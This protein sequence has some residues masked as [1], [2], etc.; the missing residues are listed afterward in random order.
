MQVYEY[1]SERIADGRLPSG[2]V[3]NIGLLADE[4][5]VS[6]PTVAHAL[7]MLEADAKVKRFAGIGWQVQ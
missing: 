1:L 2:T 4:H 7:R 6:R 5:N 3:L